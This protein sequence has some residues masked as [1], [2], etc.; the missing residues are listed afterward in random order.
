MTVILRR[1][2]DKAKIREL[3]GELKRASRFDPMKYCGALKIKHSPLA[4]QK[5]LRD[6]WQ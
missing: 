1:A 4:I 3:L 5:A 2:A 6:E